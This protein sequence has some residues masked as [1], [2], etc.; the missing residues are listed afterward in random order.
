MKIEQ[1]VGTFNGYDVI[2]RRET[3]NFHQE[4]CQKDFERTADY[5]REHIFN[6][7]DH[8][9]QEDLVNNKIQAKKVADNKIQASFDELMGYPMAE[10]FLTEKIVKGH[11]EEWKKRRVK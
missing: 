9:L 6:R 7:I 2:I 3:G 5:L 11:F 8:Q 4:E 1:E 10:G